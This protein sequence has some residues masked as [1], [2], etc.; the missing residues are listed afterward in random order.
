M[1]DY[2]DKDGVT[3]LELLEWAEKFEDES[4][5][6]VAL[7]ITN[8]GIRVSTV[9]LGLD[10]GWDTEREDYKPLIFES[11]AFNDQDTHTVQFAPHLPRHEFPADLDQERYSTLEEAVEGHSRMVAKYSVDQKWLDAQIGGNHEDSPE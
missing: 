11:M 3:K 6:R 2:W 4:Y 7:D 9:W 1:G 5:K 8:E 10:H